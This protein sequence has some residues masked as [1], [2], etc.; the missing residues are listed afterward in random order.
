MKCQGIMHTRELN[1]IKIQLADLRKG[2]CTRNEIPAGIN[3]TPHNVWQKAVELRPSLAL[4]VR[5]M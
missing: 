1:L 4:V 5:R 2:L 3:A